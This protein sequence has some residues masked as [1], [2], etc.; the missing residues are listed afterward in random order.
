MSYKIID[1]PSLGRPFNATDIIEVSAD[2]TGSYKANI[3]NF[4]LGGENYICLLYTSDA[5]DEC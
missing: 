1:L 5:A 4:T 3:G 2:G